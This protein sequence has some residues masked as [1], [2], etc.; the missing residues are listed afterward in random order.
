MA[1]TFLEAIA[2]QEGFYAVGTRPN[3]NNNPGDIE[4]GEFARSHGATR[5]D[6]RFAI[7]DSAE[8]GFSAMRSLLV[9]AGY[10][11]L[12]VEA[13]LNKWAPPVENATNIYIEHVCEWVGCLPTDIVG[14]L[15]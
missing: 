9:G 7:F 15:L 6:G 10:E 3:R 4:F 14:T 5:S 2:R 1:M 8:D 13:A 11:Y 12:T